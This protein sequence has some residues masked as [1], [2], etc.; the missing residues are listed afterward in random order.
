MVTDT[1]V[2]IIGFRCSCRKA[3]YNVLTPPNLPT[4]FQTALFSVILLHFERLA[5]QKPD[6]LLLRLSVRLCFYCPLV[7]GV[8]SPR[9]LSSGGTGGGRSSVEGR[10]SDDAY[11]EDGHPL[12]AVRALLQHSFLKKNN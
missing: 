1:V 3:I 8:I 2:P 6:A 4:F 12:P 10:G 7:R 9:R 11:V 5:P